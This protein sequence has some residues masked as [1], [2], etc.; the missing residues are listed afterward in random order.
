MSDL[1]IHCATADE[2]I[3]PLNGRDW[4]GPDIAVVMP[5]EQMLDVLRELDDD[6][7]G[8]VALWLRMVDTVGCKVLLDYDRDATRGL[9]H[10]TPCDPQI[11]HRSRYMHFLFE[12]LA[13][14][15]GRQELL[16]DYLEERGCYSDRRPRNPRETTAALRSFI[17]TGGRLLLTPAGRVFIGG[18]VPRA[19]IDGTDEEVEACRVATM[20]FIDVRKRYRADPQL[21]R[22]L[23]MLGTPTNNGWRVLEA[24][25]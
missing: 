17:Q 24:A 2:P 13:R 15:D 9:M 22:A 7:V 12:D 8:Y 19:L 10:W 6:E 20:T 4:Q 3:Q 5:I 14:I 21:K 23:R 18:G 1:P 11:R 16:A 25:A